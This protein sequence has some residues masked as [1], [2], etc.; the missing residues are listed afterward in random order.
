[1]RITTQGILFTCF[2][3]Y[4]AVVESATW[5]SR[6]L[7]VLDITNLQ[8]SFHG[9]D[10]L[11]GDNRLRE[12]AFGHSESMATYGFFSHTTLNGP[13]GATVS[14]RVLAAG[15]AWNSPPP[16]Q[17]GA[18]GE[19]IAGVQGYGS[20]GGI[21]TEFDPISAARDVMYGTTVLSELSNFDKDTVGGDGFLSWDEVGDTWS[22]QNWTQWGDG[23]M[24]STGH[25]GNILDALYTDLGVGYFWEP[26]DA[27]PILRDAPNSPLPFPLRTYWTQNFGAGDTDPTY[28]V[29]VP[30]GIWLFSSALLFGVAAVRRK[31]T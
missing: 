8:R 14:D 28:F 26:G 2:L 16:G 10:A 18:V 15:Y 6:E 25:R 31:Q 4:S 24:G 29:P 5:D 30:A 21:P 20:M 17:T 13:N 27:P 23:W 1:M 7:A 19:N 22:E 12:A 11:N 9:L 3:A